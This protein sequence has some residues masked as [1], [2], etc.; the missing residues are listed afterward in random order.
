MRPFLLV[1]TCLAVCAGCA[2]APG[3]TTPPA[4]VDE[5]PVIFAVVGAVA[6]PLGCH[7]AR[8]VACLARI[9]P[10]ALAR[11]FAGTELRLGAP[12]ATTACGGASGLAADLPDGTLVVWPSPT[13]V[14]RAVRDVSEPDRARL[15]AQ[16]L[17]TDPTLSGPA[18]ARA[19]LHADLDGDTTPDTAYAA[20]IPTL[21]AVFVVPGALPTLLR[22]LQFNDLAPYDLLGAVDLD[23]SRPGMQLILR[24]GTDV[25]VVTPTGEVL[26]SLRC[27]TSPPRSD[28]IRPD[29]TLAG[30]AQ[31]VER[32]L[33]KP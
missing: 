12:A 11:T 30:L 31:L 26:S 4:A 16:L 17:K 27:L 1:T 25:D 32:R 33:P 5:S 20:G 14:V 3:R 6:V 10:R 29:V 24:T 28:R 19:A 15:E 13:P 18:V 22:I 23:P 2:A 9:P 8:G 7:D 21:H